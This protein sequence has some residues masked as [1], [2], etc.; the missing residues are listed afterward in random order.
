M[1]FSRVLNELKRKRQVPEQKV[2]LVNL[3]WATTK[4]AK[5]RELESRKMWF[6]IR[7]C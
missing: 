6:R 5:G 3:S 1:I 7:S 4:K 2:V